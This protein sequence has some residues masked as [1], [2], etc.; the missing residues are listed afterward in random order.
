MIHFPAPLIGLLGRKRSGKDTFAAELVAEYGF[1]RVA[2]ADP[3]RRVMI[4]L[5]P[6]V[7]IEA[8]EVGP[9][10]PEL[11]LP[12]GRPSTL[13]LAALV[14]AVGWERAKDVREVRRLLQSHGVAIRAHVDPDAWV[15][16][17]QRVVNDIRGPWELGGTYHDGTPGPTDWHPGY[18]VVVTDVRFLNEARAI[19]A[20]G[21]TLV[22][23]T[24]PGQ[25][26]SDL[27]VSETELDDFAVDVEIDNSG[28]IEDLQAQARILAAELGA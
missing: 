11:D 22:R 15:E 6:L 19:R 14:D 12:L 1:V 3:L 2:F 23:I 26:A 18:P 20:A 27:H 4:D 5:D 9:L 17:A 10:R 13:R 21:G 8:A 25:D 24:R 16:A 7:V 28:T